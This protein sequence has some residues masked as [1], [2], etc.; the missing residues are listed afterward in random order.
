MTRAPTSPTVSVLIPA[1]NEERTIER[2]LRRIL[3][4]GGLVREIVVVD[5]G[6]RDRTAEIAERVS[7]EDRRIRVLHQE[8]NQGKTAAIRP[9]LGEAVGDVIIVQD[10][11]LEYDPAET[12]HVGER[13][14]G[15]SADV[16][17]GSRF[18]VRRAARVRVHAALPATTEADWPDS[19]R[20]DAQ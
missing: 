4:L 11:D 14:L 9:A 3:T 6:S 20:P 16:V 19:G 1:Y 8:K 10:A 17:C 2:V 18:L 15:G 13:I 7:E 5:D 12:P